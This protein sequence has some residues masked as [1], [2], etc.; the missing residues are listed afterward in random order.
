MAAERIGVE[1]ITLPSVEELIQIML[2]APVSYLL[3][4]TRPGLYD[5][6]ELNSS[7]KVTLSFF[8]DYLSSEADSFLYQKNKD[9]IIITN[10]ESLFQHMVLMILRMIILFKPFWI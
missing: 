5:L 2:H 4:I 8:L 7:L 10:C 6:Q 1:N 9:P 3:A